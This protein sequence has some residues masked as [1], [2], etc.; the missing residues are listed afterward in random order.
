MQIDVQAA[1][2]EQILRLQPVKT[3]DIVGGFYQRKLTAILTD[4]GTALVAEKD[5]EIKALKDRGMA[6]G[7][8]EDTRDDW[9]NRCYGAEQRAEQAEAALEDARAI[10]GDLLKG[11]IK[12]EAAL[13]ELRRYVTYMERREDD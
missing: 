12:A 2:V 6:D 4:Y 7:I 1:A 13:A 9:I 10:A 3:L 8:Y 5:F 11:K